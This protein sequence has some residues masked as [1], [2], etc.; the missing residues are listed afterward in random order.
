MDK[1]KNDFLSVEDLYVEYTSGKKV[2]HAL[3]GLSFSMKKGETLGLVGETGAGKT[4]LAKSVMRILP[5]PP[6][7][8]RSGNIWF[9]GN[10]LLKLPEKSMLGVRGKKIAMIFQDP[11]TA[12]NPVRSVGSQIADCYLLHECDSSAEAR[13]RAEE[14]LQH[15]GIPVTRYDEFP[16]QFSGGMKQRVVIAMALACNPE[17]ILADEPTTALDV[18]IQAQ[19]LSL[20]KE[21]KEKLGSSMILI[22]H[23]LGVVAQTCDRVIVLYAG[24]AVEEGSK[25]DI[26]KN[27]THPYT[28]GL[29]A[30]LPDMNNKVHRL[31][32]IRGLPADPTD[33]PSG[34]SFHPRCPQATERC[35]SGPIPRVEISPGHSCTCCNVKQ[36][37]AEHE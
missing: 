4:T 17:L 12:L 7:R 20:M 36:G 1:K 3:N 33:L 2:T 34:C 10:D 31:T 19:V 28:K 5:D 24:A 16:F 23:D 6:A 26:F 27:P 14:M 9:Q 32:P 35:K 29:L 15:V 37:G 18:T 11:M 13:K 25:Y 21:L 8:I 22:T 30:S